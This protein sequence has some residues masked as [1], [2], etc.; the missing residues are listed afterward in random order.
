MSRPPWHNEFPVTLTEVVRA[1]RAD[2]PALAD[3]DVVPL[4]AGFDFTTFLAD[5]RWVVRFPKRRSAARALAK[6]VAL[7]ERL[8]RDMTPTSVRTI[9]YHWYV[10]TPTTVKLPYAVYGYLDGTPLY[11]LA[12]EPG[13]V[14]S[15]ATPMGEFL[16]ALHAVRIG[17]PP[18]HLDERFDEHIP[19]LRTYL[20]A[21]DDLVPLA[22][23][24]R[25]ERLLATTLPPFEGEPRLCHADLLSEHIFVRDDRVSVIDWGDARWDDP[26]SDFVGLWTWAGDRAVRIAC[27][28]Y[29]AEPTATDWHRIRYKGIC[30]CIGQCHFGLRDD[31]P[32]LLRG[33]LAALD[34]IDAAGQIAAPQGAY[35]IDRG[36]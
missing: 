34:R 20:A 3:A 24:E 35:R 6:E 4:G 32:E 16:R 30:V 19:E 27:L 14:T 2:I 26:W 1:L 29:G 8:H 17:S 5:G 31:H 12:P 11:E 7:L 25:L 21:L 13:L 9:E 10:E 36:N 18:R 23:R 22:R 28:T 33:T 15:V